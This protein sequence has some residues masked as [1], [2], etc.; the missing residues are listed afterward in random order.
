MFLHGT[1]DIS[2][3]K[4]YINLE[5]VENDFAALRR[6]SLEFFSGYEIAK[7]NYLLGGGRLYSVSG[8]MELLELGSRVHGYGN[9]FPSSLPHDVIP[10]SERKP[11]NG[12]IQ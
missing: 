10:K 4:I 1:Q 6:R 5:P 8:E 2:T 12:V 3:D 11:V 7:M 9:D